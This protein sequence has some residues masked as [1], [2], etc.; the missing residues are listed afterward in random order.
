MPEGQRTALLWLP[1]AFALEVAAWEVDSRLGLAIV[2]PTWEEFGR[3]I[4]V[5]RIVWVLGASAVV[6][7]VLFSVV[8]RRRVVAQQSLVQLAGVLAMAG[9]WIGAS[10]Y[11]SGAVVVL[12]TLGAW[13]LAR[14]PPA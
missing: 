1:S 10:V 7:T 2:D 5:E 6:L 3:S 11:A 14:R 4:G 13:W 8:S 12:A 9:Y